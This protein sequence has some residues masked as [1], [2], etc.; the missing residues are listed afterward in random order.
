ML[1][2]LPRPGAINLIISCCHLGASGSE[3]D[4]W[5]GTFDHQAAD[6]G[7]LCYNICGTTWKD[8]GFPVIARSLATATVP[9]SSRIFFAWRRMSKS[10]MSFIY[11]PPR[12]HSLGQKLQ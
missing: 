9:R 3:M 10:E 4:P 12:Q 11:G 8:R 1:S 6:F 7:A 2:R 5:V